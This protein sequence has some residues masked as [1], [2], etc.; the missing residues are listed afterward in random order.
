[1]IAAAGRD[2]AGVFLVRLLRLDPQALVR[3][4]PGAANGTEMW[5]MLPFRVLVM[6]TL[7]TSSEADRTVAA[8]DLLASLSEPGRALARHDAA[9]RWPLP[10]SR[11]RAVET[12]PAYEV[13]RVAAAASRTLR[14]AATEGVGGRVVGERV[15]RDALLDHVPIVVTSADGETADI[16]QRLVQAVVRMGF[17][18]RVTSSDSA[19]AL[20]S[21][22]AP[23]PAG[24]N[25]VTVRLAM[26]W[27]GLD[28]SYGSAWYR[29]VSPLRLS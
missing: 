1:V 14:L 21:H 28:A 10:S 7:S 22:H 16:P 15:V 23:L 17:L 20:G 24:D 4:R 18:G 26:G 3:L 6:R 13:T 8:A 29:P 27:I 11:G 19:S 2:D 5:A 12:I 9:W 25:T